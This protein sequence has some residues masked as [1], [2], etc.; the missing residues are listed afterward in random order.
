MKVDKSADGFVSLPIAQQKIISS[1]FHPTGTFV[2]LPKDEIEQPVPRRFEQQVLEH[3]QRLAIKSKRY[4]WNYDDLNRAANRIAW[5]IL[6]QQGPGEESIAL[7]LEKDAPL[8][9]AILGILKAGKTYV[10]L[11]PHYPRS[12]IAYI[13]ENSLAALILTN[14][15]NSA[16]A[17]ELAQERLPILNIEELSEASSTQNPV[18]TMTPDTPCW[19]IYTSGSTGQPKGV[20]QTHRNVLHFVMNYTNYLHI[21]AED[22][23]TLLFNAS[24]NGA[25]HDIFTALLVGAA[26]FP[27]GIQEDGLTELPIWLKDQGITIYTSVPTVFRHFLENLPDG[28]EFP[29]LRL[30]RL[31]GEPVLKKDVDLYKTHFSDE[32]VFVNRLGS[33]ETGSVLFNLIDK[34]FQSQEDNVPVGYPVEGNEVLFLGESGEELGFGQVGEIAVRSRYLS[35]GYWR[36]PDLTEPAFLKKSTPE[37]ESIYLMGDLG[38]MKPDGCVVCLGRKDFQVKVRG[39]RI[40][41][42]EVESALLEMPEIKEAVAHP[43]QDMAGEQRLVAYLVVGHGT[44]PTITEL[45]EHLS[46]KLPEYMVPSY[47]VYLCSLPSLPNGKVDRKSLPSPDRMRPELSRSYVVPKTPEQKI[48]ADIWSKVLGVEKV[49][50]HDSFLELGGDSLLAASMFAEMEKRFDKKL[51]L[52]ILVQAGTIEQLANIL[53]NVDEAADW[54]SLVALQPDGSKPPLFFVHGAGGHVLGFTALAQYLGPDQPVY[55]LEA[56]GRDGEQDPYDRLADLAAHYLYEIQRVQPQGPYFLGGLCMGGT[57]AYEM[58]QQLRRSGESVSLLALLDTPMPASIPQRSKINRSWQQTRRIAERLLTHGR[59]FLRTPPKKKLGFLIGK[60]DVAKAMM[61]PDS[62]VRRTNQLSAQRYTPQE[63]PGHVSVFI[64]KDEPVVYA[65]DPRFQ[66]ESVVT[67]SVAV[68][69]VPGNQSEMLREPQVKVLAAKLSGCI[70]S[71]SKE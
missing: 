46:Q 3:P 49:G 60:I 54:S 13:L 23:L 40:E 66:W 45:R 32:C 4:H 16:L 25:S 67:G 11:D 35:Q 14:H 30:V 47:Y 62:P 42:A 68:F 48:L 12:R 71:A 7:L 21:C 57:I 50:I 33:T 17:E 28:I 53:L 36:R 8:I 61:T 39:H 43:R 44:P 18:C 56:P 22:R 6:G 58:A 31:I 29:E 15:Q 69:S 59:S 64:A 1:C 34:N 70:E 52:S 41:A 19:I 37:D 5:G 20:P 2:A 26:L 38:Y 63:Y 9:A 10:P 24:V 55:G 51:P 65:P 27:F